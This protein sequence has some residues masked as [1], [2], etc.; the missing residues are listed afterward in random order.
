MPS[1]AKRAWRNQI[2]QVLTEGMA[3]G[4]IRRFM[5]NDRGGTTDLAAPGEMERAF[6]DMVASDS[7]FPATWRHFHEILA[8]PEIIREYRTMPDEGE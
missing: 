4:N 7:E 6:L 2:V 8:L 3:N 1:P 5:H